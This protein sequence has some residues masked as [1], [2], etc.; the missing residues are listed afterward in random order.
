MGVI[1]HLFSFHNIYHKC[2]VKRN[3][4][5]LK[6]GK[7]HQKCC[8]LNETVRN[9]SVSGSKETN[10]MK[11]T[12]EQLV[13]LISE[14][15]KRIL[16]EYGEESRKH[17]RLLGA[18]NRE[19]NQRVM[20]STSTENDANLLRYVNGKMRRIEKG[21]PKASRDFMDGMEIKKRNK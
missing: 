16:M 8:V 12:E 18:L 9:N 17:R 6:G 20:K 4:V 2:L 15:V 11:L 3:M 7:Q 13:E 10:L 19:L 14:S 5:N 21:N 1:P